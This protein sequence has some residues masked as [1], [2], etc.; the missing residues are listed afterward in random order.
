VSDLPPEVTTVDLYIGDR[1]YSRMSREA[2]EEELEIARV[3]GPQLRA[4]FD[5]A[6]AWFESG[7]LPPACLAPTRAAPAPSL[8]CAGATLTDCPA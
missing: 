7:A 6:L 5:K 3:V 8:A 4:M 1:F 2:Y